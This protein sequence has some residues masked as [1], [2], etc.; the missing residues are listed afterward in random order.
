MLLET[1]HMEPFVTWAAPIAAAILTCFG[2]MLV[3]V[4][5]R[6]LNLRMDE[7]ERKHTE[8]RAKTEEKRRLEAEWRE[9]V[10]E[11][12]KEQDDVIKT[13]LSAQCTQMRS[14]ITHRI[15]RYVDDLGC[16]SSE[17]KQSLYSEYEEYCEICRR[18]GITNHFVDQMMKQV[19]SLPDRSK[20]TE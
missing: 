11:R 13:I 6:K 14:D 5:Q 4:G 18:Y 9:S 2:Q 20:R 17:E 7:E 12:L 8:A 16:A 15:H 19:M 10:D 3:A 1:A